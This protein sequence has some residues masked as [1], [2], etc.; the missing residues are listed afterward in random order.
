[1]TRRRLQ[2][3]LLEAICVHDLCPCRDEIGHELFFRIV[4]SI[5]FGDCTQ[6]G[7]RPENEVDRCCG[8]LGR[9]GCPV[10]A[11]IQAR[12]RRRLR[13]DC[14]HGQQVGEEVVGQRAGLAGED[15]CSRTARIRSQNAHTADQYG[16]FCNG[17]AKQVRLVDQRFGG[18]EIGV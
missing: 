11:F 1:M 15:T 3:G 5:Y 12:I 7:I 2:F 10:L 9:T 13:P 8:P 16:R 14:V 6:L 4:R 17:Q 18:T